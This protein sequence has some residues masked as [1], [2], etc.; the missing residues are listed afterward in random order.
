VKT[1]TTATTPQIRAIKKGKKP[2]HCTEERGFGVSGNKRNNK[3]R[4]RENAMP[5]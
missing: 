5:G 1:P 3:T 4:L 2:L